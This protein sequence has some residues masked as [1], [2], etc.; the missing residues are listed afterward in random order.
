M[1]GTRLVSARVLIGAVF[2]LLTASEVAAEAGVSRIDR[3]VKAEMARQ[4]IRI[5]VPFGMKTARLATDED[6]VANRAAG[7]RIENGALKHQ[8]WVAPSLN[9]TGDGGL[10]F[11]VTD[12]I[13]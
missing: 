8:E 6:L 3:F 2:A 5:F 9:R 4:R 12:L 11:S 7:Y 1:R 13:A 10:L